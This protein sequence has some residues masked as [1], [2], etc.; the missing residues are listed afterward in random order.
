MGSKNNPSPRNAFEKLAEKI[1]SKYK[2]D[3]IIPLFEYET[4]EIEYTL[5]KNYVPD[6]IV[7]KQNGSKVYIEMKG[8]LRPEDRTKMIAVKKQHPEL[9]IRIV[10]E[11]NHPVTKG[12]KSKYTDWATRNGF[13]CAMNK[14]PQEWLV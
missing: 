1:L 7:T 4:E 2:K 13:P 11:R 5:T 3:K 8:Y 6:F 12:S 14:I 10:F 9:D